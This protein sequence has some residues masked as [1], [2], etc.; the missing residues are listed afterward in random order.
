M[1]AREIKIIE[2]F[3]GKVVEDSAGEVAGK[4]PSAY[5]ARVAYYE[6]VQ[7][8]IDARLPAGSKILYL[9]EDC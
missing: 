8:N 5:E 6:A 3:G 2:S 7:R 9:Y 1:S 4:F